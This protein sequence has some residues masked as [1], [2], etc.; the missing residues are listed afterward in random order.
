[1]CVYYNNPKEVVV[2][3]T[4]KVLLFVQVCKITCLYIFISCQSLHHCIKM[5]DSFIIKKQFAYNELVSMLK[6]Q[7]TTLQWTGNNEKNDIYYKVFKTTL[8][9][10]VV[11]CPN[12]SVCHRM[13][14]LQ[15][16]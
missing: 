1:M 12:I 9:Q 14:E 3:E 11:F 2:F 13:I 10:K 7:M 4:C 15:N 6:K 8:F 5:L 16:Q